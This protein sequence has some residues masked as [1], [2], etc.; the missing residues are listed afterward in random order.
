M[1]EILVGDWDEIELGGGEIDPP[2]PGHGGS[3]LG[4]DW[5]QSHGDVTPRENPTPPTKCL[6]VD[7]KLWAKAS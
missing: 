3:I 7:P 2:C 6:G 4:W 5:F 1:W